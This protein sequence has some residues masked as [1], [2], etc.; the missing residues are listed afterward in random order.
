MLNYYV[1]RIHRLLLSIEQLEMMVIV[2]FD[3][4]S[5]FV[6]QAALKL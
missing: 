3:I 1:L 6:G 2:V 5:C 4:A